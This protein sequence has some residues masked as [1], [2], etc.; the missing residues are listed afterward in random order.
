MSESSQTRQVIYNK[1][2]ET[3]ILDDNLRALEWRATKRARDKGYPWVGV[4]REIRTY[5]WLTEV[6]WYYVEVE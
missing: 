2:V 1:L 6:S 4:R 5:G 3:D